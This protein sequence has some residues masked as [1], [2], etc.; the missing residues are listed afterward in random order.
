MENCL[1]TKLKGVVDNENLPTLNSLRVSVHIDSDFPEARPY[2]FINSNVS[3]VPTVRI[4]GDYTF[5]DTGTKVHELA[6]SSGT[7]NTNDIVFP[8]GTYELEISHK[9]ET[10]NLRLGSNNGGML[11]ANHRNDAMIFNVEDLAYSSELLGFIYTY[12]DIYGDIHKI[13]E[14][15]FVSKVNMIR[16]S[17]CSKINGT[18]KDLCVISRGVFNGSRT[19]SNSVVIEL[20][21]GGNIGKSS[22]TGS[23]LEAIDYV[24]DIAIADAV[25]RLEIGGNTTLDRSGIELPSAASGVYTFTFDGNGSYTVV[26]S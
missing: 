17:G 7:Y 13:A 22:I 3:I 9:Y 6:L 25:L 20:K 10:V 23:I 8:Y 24:K 11:I 21:E 19:D 14:R 16:L 1:V 5:A 2:I 26:G 18:L 15:G 4:I 12:Q